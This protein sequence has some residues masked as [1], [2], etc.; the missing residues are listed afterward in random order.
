MGGDLIVPISI[1]VEIAEI[2]EANDSEGSLKVKFNFT[3]DGGTTEASATK[4]IKLF[5][6]QIV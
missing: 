4:E 5:G 1:K 3:R 6:F 2:M